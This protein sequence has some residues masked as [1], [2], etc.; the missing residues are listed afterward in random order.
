MHTAVPETP[1]VAVQ[2]TGREPLFL[3]MNSRSGKQ[4]SGATRQAI[5]TACAEAG[6][7]CELLVVERGADLASA[8]RKAVT[9]A[10]EQGGIVVAVGGDGT[11]NAVCQAVVGQGVPFGVLPQGTFNYFGRAHGISQDTGQAMHDL[12]NARLEHISLGQI[13]G[14]YFLVN[15]SLGLYPQLLEDREEYKQ[16]YGRSRWI[17][18]VA[19][20]VTLARAH[21][22]LDITLEH[23][24]R[25]ER[26]R[27]PTLVVC[28]NALQLK[29][30]GVDP[31][32][33]DNRDHLVALASRP[34][35][36]GA[37]YLLLL[38]GLLS[39]MGEAEN[40]ISFGFEN[41]TVRPNARPRMVKVAVD[42]EILRMRTPLTFRIAP[43]VLPLLIPRSAPTPE[44]P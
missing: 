14:R 15:A 3:V 43:H 33:P 4:D 21:R 28:N 41:L 10:R 5:R 26:L 18:L 27:T 19:A 6:R 23:G 31:A 1:A 13:N 37:L 8:A 29:H 34:V 24:G 17:A 36:T 44:H 7:R 2:L 22:Q 40:V 39:R 42:G 38:Q 12:L 20:L 35:G 30:I 32:L 25:H 11:L 16:R 9:L